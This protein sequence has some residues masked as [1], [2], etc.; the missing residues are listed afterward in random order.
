MCGDVAAKPS[1]FGTLDGLNSP[2]TFPFGQ[3][4][5]FNFRDLKYFVYHII[6][7]VAKKDQP[8]GAFCLPEPSQG[9]QPKAVSLLNSGDAQGKGSAT[10]YRVYGKPMRVYVNAPYNTRIKFCIL[11]KFAFFSKQIP[12]TSQGY[13]RIHAGDIFSDR[14]YKQLRLWWRKTI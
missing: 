4:K 3:I 8:F 1:Q 10:Q 12:L 14:S 6:A 11:F 7:Q 5:Y 9:W 13:A 2:L